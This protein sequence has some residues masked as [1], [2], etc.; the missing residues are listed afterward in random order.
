MGNFGDD[1]SGFSFAKLAV[2][3]NYKRWAR[4][5]QYSLEFAGFWDYTFSDKENPKPVAIDFKD[6]DLENDA[7]L[8]RQEKRADKIIA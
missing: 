8:Q 2:T 3:N 6:K 1:E 5:M 4:E 7:K